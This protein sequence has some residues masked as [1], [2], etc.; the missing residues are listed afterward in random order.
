MKQKGE[1]KPN[2]PEK[3]SI[4]Q[5]PKIKSITKKKRVSQRMK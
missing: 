1:E 4:K 3:Q 5:T 2:D